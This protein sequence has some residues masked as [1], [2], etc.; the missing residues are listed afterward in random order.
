MKTTVALL[1]SAALVLALSAPASAASRYSKPTACGAGEPAYTGWNYWEL[2]AYGL[3]CSNAHD[4]ATEYVY[5]FST[6][7]VIEP[8]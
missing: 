1:L 3:K 5:D 8:P 2:Q 7:G 4:A 6:E